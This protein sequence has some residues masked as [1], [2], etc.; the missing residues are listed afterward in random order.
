MVIMKKIL[1]LSLLGT[2]LFSCGK[3]QPIDATV[4]ITGSWHLTELIEIDTRS[5]TIG[6]E[7]VDIYLDLAKDNTFRLYQMVGTGK[8]RCFT[9]TWSLNENTLSGIYSDGTPW[10]TQYEVELNETSTE[11]T[12]T[13]KGEKY[14]YS[15]ELIPEKILSGVR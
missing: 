15:K 7:I 10:G 9:G 5:V 4:D 12:L 6:Q 2:L 14:V 13:G 11:L 1:F 8:Y 3:E